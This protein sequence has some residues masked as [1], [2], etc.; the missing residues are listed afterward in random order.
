[1][2]RAL[3]AA[4]A[5]AV[6]TSL[7]VGGTAG[8]DAVTGNSWT[9][10]KQA[11]ITLDGHGYGHGHGL[12]QYGAQARADDGQTAHQIVSWYYRKTQDGTAGGKVTV[13]ISED[14]NSL[15]V[16]NRSG[17]RLHV[18]GT[19]TSWDL[20]TTGTAGKATRWKLYSGAAGASKAAYYVDGTWHLWKTL[21]SDAELVGGNQGLDLFLPG[22]PVTYRGS[23][24]S[25]RTSE[26]SA[27]RVTVNK[28]GLESYLQGVVPREVPA[29]WHPAAVKA[30]AIAA[31]TYAAYERR[32]PINRN[33]Q[34]CDT[35][36][37]QVYGGKSA[38]HPASN[39]AVKETAGQIR[40]Y[41]GQPAFT[42]FSSSNG[43][44]TAAGSV[45]YLEAR[46]DP[47]DAWS[48]N[49]NHDWTTSVTSTQIENAWPALGDLKTIDITERDGHG[50]WGGRVVSLTLHGSSAKVVRTGEQFR[51]M[52][53]LRS[54][55]FKVASVKPD[56]FAKLAA[57]PIDYVALGD[58][59]SA[60]P[61][62]PAQRT[63]PAGCLRSTNNYPAYLAGYLKV[64]TYR[65]VTCSGARVR[66]FDHRQST[67]IP[68]PSPKPQVSALSKG[69][70]LVTIGIGGNDFGLFGQMTDVCPS[71]AK[72]DP[73][74]A[75]CKRHFTN[76]DGVNTKYRDAKRIQKHIARA[77]RLVRAKAPNAKIDLVGYPRLLPGRGT[78]SEVGFAKG[79]YA[80]ARHVAYLLNRSIRRA[81]RHH[82]A[83]YLGTY[84]A[85]KGHDICAG[86]KAWIHGQGNTATAAAY[87]P[88]QKGERGLGRTVFHQI[89]GRTAPKGGDAAPPPGSIILNTP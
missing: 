3:P 32:E 20:P 65:D 19:T 23:L 80:F 26:G 46:E 45:P 57:R 14:D 18:I 62:I 66:D 44:W 59:Y 15:V 4:L 52:F 84:G 76:A 41:D 36:L 16:R 85:S 78:C 89:T 69:T 48:G 2:P 38:E 8:S 61:L 13:H 87:H 29:L 58:S 51:S 47:Y 56:S 81:A 7:V 6:L 77:I 25:R 30:Q 83:H 75:P 27:G 12:S 39:E 11:V 70:D 43:G 82:H 55:W 10:P 24:Q 71:V 86:K 73:Q 5:A 22:G 35:S 33:Y 79:D 1:M 53:G 50:D 28:L 34:I 37:C 9:V 64:R 40:T 68:G 21:P 63:D 67:I 42:Q 49:P 74:G 31:R 88:Y 72:D 17:I 60:G 54:T